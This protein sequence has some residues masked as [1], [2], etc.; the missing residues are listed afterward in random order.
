MLLNIQNI[1]KNYG[2]EPMIVP[3]LKDVSL[4]VVQGDYIAIMGPSGSGKTTLM[5]IIGCLDRA[6]LGTYLF[7][8]EDISEMND[9]ALSDLRLN[10]IGFVFQ[11]FNLLSSE[12]AQE[13]VAL[14]LIYAGID[15]EKRNQ[16]A[17]DVLNKVGLQDRISFKPS[18]L[19][20]GQKQRVAIARA[21][22][23]NPKILLA[24][25]PTGA[26]DQAS[27]KQVMELFKSLNDEGV[28]IIM[29]THDANVASH[30]KKILHIID[31]EIIENK[32][33]GVL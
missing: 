4:E 2:K 30:A 21:I 29:I 6:S 14:P 33:G 9:D 23:N 7:E 8:D 22:I 13:N 18:Q 12:T 25:E 11:N 10:K 17:I 19:S 20:G 27:G 5:N 16:R 24:D 1:Y 26:L 28:T 3:V 15:K 31:G 32:Q